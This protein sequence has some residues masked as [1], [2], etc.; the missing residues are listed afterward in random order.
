MD[1]YTPQ[2]FSVPFDAKVVMA[3]CPTC[4]AA[5]GQLCADVYGR[6]LRWLHKSRLEASIKQRERA[7]SKRPL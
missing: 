7:R 6:A 5:P 4:N 2:L 1:A 3:P